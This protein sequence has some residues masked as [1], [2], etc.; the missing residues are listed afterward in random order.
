[1]VQN[2]LL[3]VIFVLAVA[4]IAPVVAL[5]ANNHNP[6]PPIRPTPFDP[7]RDAV[8]SNMQNPSLS[9]H[10]PQPVTVI[11]NVP[12]VPPVPH[13]QAPR[14]AVSTESHL[15]RLPEFMEGSSTG[16]LPRNAP[17]NQPEFVVGSPT[18][19]TNHPSREQFP[20]SEEVQVQKGPITAK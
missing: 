2:K 1:M 7:V 19:S 18:G 6:N 16:S 5:P 14:R 4:A 17:H 12:P 11:Q 8:A 20:A 9:G 15:L 10:A 13:P 3:S